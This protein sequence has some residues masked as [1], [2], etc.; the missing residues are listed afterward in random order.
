MAGDNR[1]PESTGG[2]MTGGSRAVTLCFH[3]FVGDPRLHWPPPTPAYRERVEQARTALVEPGCGTESESLPAVLDVDGARPAA[4]SRR[5]GT[6]ASKAH[7]RRHRSSQG[8]F[9]SFFP[10]VRTARDVPNP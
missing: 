1:A 8:R 3:A 2:R 7:S 6:A 5:F 4:A 9:T 10:L